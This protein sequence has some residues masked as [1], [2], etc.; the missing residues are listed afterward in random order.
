MCTVTLSYDGN[1]ALAR[2]DLE[3]LLGTGRFV[4]LESNDDSFANDVISEAH[5][6]VM[7][8]KEYTIEEAYEMTMKEIRTIYQME[9]AI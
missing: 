9:Y 1:N 8:K 3:V 6:R 4:K 2:Q 7:Q 5:D